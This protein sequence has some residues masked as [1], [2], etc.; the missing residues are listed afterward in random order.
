MHCWPLQ[1]APPP[2]VLCAQHGR[3]GLPQATN[4]PP[5]HTMPDALALWPGGMQVLVAGFRHAPP[6]HA[7]ACGHA[8]PYAEPQVL[9]MPR[10]VHA[11]SEL[12]IWPTATH[13]PSSSTQPSMHSWSAQTG[14]P[15]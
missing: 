13:S 5:M 8:G 14:S 3:P 9:Q 15:G 6:T 4:E 2:Q 10:A 11:R 1:H 7:G 12:H